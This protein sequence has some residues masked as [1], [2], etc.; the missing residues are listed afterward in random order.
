MASGF[1]KDFVTSR[2]ARLKGQ[3]QRDYAT[4]QWAWLNGLGPMPD[5][6]QFEIGHREA[7]AA[8]IMLASL[9]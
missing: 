3:N 9:K 4:A 6:K 5:P 7:Q 2:I 8:L 1:K